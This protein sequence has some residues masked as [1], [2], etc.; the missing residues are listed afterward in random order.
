MVMIILDV[1]GFA[2]IA[3]G[4]T[5]VWVGHHY[6][7]PLIFWGALL[8]LTIG[9]VLIGTSARRRRGIDRALRENGGPGDFGD[10]HYHSGHSADSHAD[11]DGDGD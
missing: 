10:K 9:L 11:L 6:L 8:P 4:L 7:G 3:V 2:C 1:L 5:L